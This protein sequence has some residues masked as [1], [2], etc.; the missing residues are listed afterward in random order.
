MTQPGSEIVALKNHTELDEKEILAVLLW[1][2]IKQS[3]K[4]I[5]EVAD[6]AGVEPSTMYSV[7]NKKQGLSQKKYSLLTGVLPDLFGQAV[8]DDGYQRVVL[9]Q[10]GL[11]KYK[12][13]VVAGEAILFQNDSM[14]GI[15]SVAP[16]QAPT[17]PPKVAEEARTRVITKPVP[18]KVLAS[19]IWMFRDDKRRVVLEVVA[20]YL[21][22]S[23]THLYDLLKAMPDEGS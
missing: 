3:G 11:D 18:L 2:A 19:L 8:K 10:Q 14:Y 4:K 6:Q 22:D 13:L 23:N 9:T 21:K 5:R 20:E 12:L 15:G 17:P 7:L 1:H 16:R